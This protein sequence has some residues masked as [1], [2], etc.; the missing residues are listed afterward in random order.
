MISR[1]QK[2]FSGSDVVAPAF[3][4]WVLA[5]HFAGQEE[6]QVLWL[7]YALYGAILF[8]SAPFTKRLSWRFTFGVLFWGQISVLGIFD[9]VRLYLAGNDLWMQHLHLVI[10]GAMFP[11]M[12]FMME[13]ENKSA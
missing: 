10:L 5:V 8:L 9:E 4:A 12:I 2:W 13:D 7:P 3:M 11:V 1:F 6:Y